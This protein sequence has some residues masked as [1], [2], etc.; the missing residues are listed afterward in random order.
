MEE[1]P[2]LVKSQDIIKGKIFNIAVPFV[3]ER[4]LEFVVQDDGNSDK[5]RIVTKDDGFEGTMGADGKRHADVVR[6]VTDY[7]LRPGVII[8][9]NELNNN[10]DFK[11]VIVLPI[12]SIHTNESQRSLIQRMKEKNDLPSF[13][14]LER[15][16]GKESYVIVN[17]PIRL[18][19]SMIFE[20]RREIVLDQEIMTEI[21][22]KLAKCLEIEE[23]EK[24]DQCEHNCENCELKLA[25]NS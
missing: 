13:H 6:V 11:D 1:L 10:E 17:K 7:K 22:K 15:L 16:V 5:Y 8:S 18:H 19:K 25:S 21:M 3:A 4:P 23:I 2:R 12:S 24:C 14:Y 9:S 20:A